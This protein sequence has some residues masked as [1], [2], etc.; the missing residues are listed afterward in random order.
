MLRTRRSS[1]I[2][3]FFSPS[4]SNL[5]NAPATWC[6]TPAWWTTSESISD[7]GRR[8]LARLPIAFNRFRIHF[9]K[10]R[11]VQIV[12][13]ILFKYGGR[14]STAHTMARHSLSVVSHTRSAVLSKWIQYPIDIVVLPGFFCSQ[15]N[16]NWTSSPSLSSVIRPPT[17]GNASSDVRISFSS[18]LLIASTCIPFILSSNS[19][20]FCNLLLRE[21]AC[22]AK[23]GAKRLKKLP[24][25][26]Y[27]FWSVAFR[28]T[29]RS[30]VSSVVCGAISALPTPM[31]SPK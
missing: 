28:G 7:N 20:S 2:L 15:T 13:H 30:L 22:S 31:I 9:S 3:V 29:L 12:N 25:R 18:T 21:D 5:S 27:E 19:W 11:E 17:H 8:H 4:V 16:P 26:R 6:F 1:P 24:R 23:F 14:D 10:S